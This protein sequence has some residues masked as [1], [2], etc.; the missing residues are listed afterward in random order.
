MQ[1]DRI[2]VITPD[3]P[4]PIFAGGQKRMVPIITSLAKLAK[5]QLACIAHQLPPETVAWTQDLNIKLSYHPKL[6]TQPL[7]AAVF[8]YL[9]LIA[10][11][12][13]SYNRKL[14]PFFEKSFSEFRPDLVWLETPYLLRHAIHWQKTTPL[15][16]DY[17]GTS[18]GYEREI[19]QSS[20]LRSLYYKIRW[21]AAL[22]T[23]KK[24][25]RH[26]DAIVAISEKDASYFR[27]ISPNNII[28]HIP[29]AMI[30]PVPENIGSQP[31]NQILIMTGDF[32]YK[33]NVDAAIFFTREIF[34]AI[35]TAQP[36]AEILLVGQK[37]S[38]EIIALRE[39]EK[40][41][42]V[43]SVKDLDQYIAQA[44]VY[45]L[46]MR[47]GSG[48]RSKLFDV[49]AVGRPIVTTSIGAEGL[50]LKHNDNCLIADTPASF[51][52]ACLC[53]LQNAELRHK[54]A[55]NARRLATEIYTIANTTKAIENLLM[56]IPPRHRP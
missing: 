6:T 16:V 55:Y 25:S 28:R 30:R 44:A 38:P 39:L 18:E 45:I 36:T 20:G 4:Y 1:V 41:T 51:A 12:N 11:N 17:W 49:F 23:E 29:S 56:A 22:R 3:L 50:E 26:L 40:V 54:L 53:L 48:I 27:Q 5:V 42:I 10:G 13:L 35:R 32:S 46:P 7:V 37:P 21:R 31:N 34:P 47:L 14:Q 33:P 43:G 8:R 24:L 9:N 2:L 52:S 15:I 19:Q